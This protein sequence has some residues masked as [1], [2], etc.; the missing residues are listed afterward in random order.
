M[1]ATVPGAIWHTLIK[2]HYS[3]NLASATLAYGQDVIG[4]RNR[5]LVPG[6]RTHNGA[7]HSIRHRQAMEFIMENV[8]LTP[9][10]TRISAE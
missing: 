1:A 3:S 8:D 7:N 4:L 10:D 2:G 5:V 6:E 9:G